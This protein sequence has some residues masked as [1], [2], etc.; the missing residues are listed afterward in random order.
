M[1]KI[2]VNKHTSNS[3]NS[4]REITILNFSLLYLTLLMVFLHFVSHQNDLAEEDKVI[5]KYLR[6]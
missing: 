3:L 6:H 5:K 4:S 2:V 1:K